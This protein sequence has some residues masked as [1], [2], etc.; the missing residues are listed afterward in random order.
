MNRISQGAKGHQGDPS[1]TK[2]EIFTSVLGGT[3]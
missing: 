1:P 2:K 3:E